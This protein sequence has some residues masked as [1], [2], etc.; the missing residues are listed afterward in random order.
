M[1][2]ALDVL[3]GRHGLSLELD[4]GWL[5]ATWMPMGFFIF[6][7]R[8]D[9]EKWREVLAH[10]Q[11]LALELEDIEAKRAATGLTEAAMHPLG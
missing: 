11:M 7:G 8:F 9:P 5:K 1:R 6:P 10:M 4:G 3:I 2:E